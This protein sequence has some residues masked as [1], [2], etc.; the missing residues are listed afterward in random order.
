M[1]EDETHTVFIVSD[2][3]CRTCD[4]VLQAVLVQ[5]DTVNVQLVRKANVR[6]TRTV[7]RLIKEAADQN[8]VVFYTF[9]S[10]EPRQAI[11][12]AAQRHM[13][14][15]VDILGPVLG[16]LFDLFSRLPLATPGILHE[17]NKPHFDR[18]D[19][20]EYTLNHDDGCSVQ[21]LS[22]AD[23]VLVGV[24]RAC[25]STTCFY[26]GYSGIRAANVPLF[27]D[28]DPPPE[29]LSLDRRR[30][31]GLT[32]NPH[33]LRSVREARLREW[34]IDLSADYGDERVIARELRAANEQITKH[35][36]R[37]I[38]ISYKAIEEV[39]REVRQLLKESGIEIG[40]RG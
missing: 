23:V 18:V 34:G 19:A 4:L 9:V 11:Q 5:F 32:V 3:T 7:T 14:P 21:H 33:R 8:A 29:L 13:V 28:S 39:A 38:D 26:L 30:V 2:G 1:A 15:V 10:E 20:V 36:W 40:K 22:E 25:K 16:S 31:I 6:R 17:A 27:P 24:S 37:W 12:E 35:G